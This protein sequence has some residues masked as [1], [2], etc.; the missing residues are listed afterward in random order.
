MK[1][2]LFVINPKAGQKKRKNYIREVIEIFENGGYQ[3]GVKY[4]K[5]RGDGTEIS[6]KYGNRVDLIVCMGG[7]GTL[8]EVIEGMLK[9]NV[10]TPLGYIPAGSTNDFAHSLGL[11]TNPVEQ[12]KRIIS[13]PGRMLDMGCFN[14]R[15]FVYTASA[16][17][18]VKTSYATPQR[19]KNRLGHTA[20]ILAG[21]KEV[22]H[23]KPLRL[24]IETENESIEGTYVF[25]AI[26]NS[27]KVGGIMKLDKD[28]VKFNDGFFELL[29]VDFPKNPLE[30]LKLVNKLFHQD[31][32]GKIRLKQVKKVKITGCAGIDWSLDGEEE[33]GKEQ[34]NFKV[35][36]NAINFIY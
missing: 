30:F 6:A 28:L 1:K 32:S 13:K 19:L 5:K 20:Y 9:D 34:V 4:T 36:P 3:V 22:F 8:N 29:L 7:D 17:V 23:L 14:G 12:A 18:F 10:Q 31:F 16:G 2:L 21:A 11:S 15:Y 27:T 35:V 26:N 25:A 33:K 24:K